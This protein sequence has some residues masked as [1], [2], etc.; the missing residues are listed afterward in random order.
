MAVV[1]QA[2]KENDVVELLDGVDK[3]PAGTGGTVISERGEWKL[4]EISD[5]RGVALDYVSASAPQLK[6]V[7]RHS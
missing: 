5:E 2:I 3:W 4:I 1:R 6:L 7:A